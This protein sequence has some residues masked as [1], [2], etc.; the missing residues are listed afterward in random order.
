MNLLQGPYSAALRARAGLARGE[1]ESLEPAPW[2]D[3][4]GD[5]V[6]PVDSDR[7]GH[8]L[9]FTNAMVARIMLLVLAA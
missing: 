5:V 3:V 1:A 6:D 2:A 4:H 9:D 8:R 7:D